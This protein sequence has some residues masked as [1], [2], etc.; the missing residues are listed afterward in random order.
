ME[1]FNTARPHR[2]LTPATWSNPATGS[3]PEALARERDLD[4]SPAKIVPY[5]HTAL[6]I[7]GPAQWLREGRGRV[8]AAATQTTYLPR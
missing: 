2:H 3:S 8:A 4:P 5:Y 6:V 7:R 1:P